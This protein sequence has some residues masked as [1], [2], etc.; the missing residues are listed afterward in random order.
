MNKIKVWGG[1]GG[2]KID[3]SKLKKIVFTSFLL[4]YAMTI[5]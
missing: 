3:L 1:G 5:Q 2:A 4:K